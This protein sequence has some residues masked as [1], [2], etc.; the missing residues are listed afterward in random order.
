MFG[1]TGGPFD[2]SGGGGGG[3]IASETRRPRDIA[4][5]GRSVGKGCESTCGLFV[6]A[7]SVGDM[8]IG[9]IVLD[10]LEPPL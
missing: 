2:V 10:T 7:A 3:K 6:F 1:F 9:V 5:G 8:S 4:S